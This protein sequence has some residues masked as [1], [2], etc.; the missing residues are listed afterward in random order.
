MKANIKTVFSNIK[1][2]VNLLL[3]IWIVE[4]VNLLSGN[5]FYS[6]GLYPR[7]IGS[8]YGIITFTF[9]H[10]SLQHA[11]FNT[12]PLFVLGSLS[13]INGKKEFVR[14]T[15]FVIL[16][17]G[18]LLWFFGRSSYHVGA[19]L[20]I[21]GYFGYLLSNAWH[22]KTATA[23]IAAILT[24]VLYGGLIYGIFPAQSYISWEGH[25]FGFF[26]GLIAAGKSK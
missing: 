15:L 6:F 14:I 7:R 2:V 17:G 26:A 19:S 21:F 16:A 13:A 10:G 23:I 18:L 20:L 22:K 4:I 3:I 5:T 25:L 12:I 9:I 24:I 11:F 1:I 8:L